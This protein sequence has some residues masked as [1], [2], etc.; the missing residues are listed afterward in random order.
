MCLF[1]CTLAEA[2]LLAPSSLVYAVVVF[3]AHEDEPNWRQSTDRDSV[4]HL[5]CDLPSFLL[6]VQDNVSPE[7][8]SVGEGRTHVNQLLVLSGFTTHCGPLCSEVITAYTWFPFPIFP[9][10][11]HLPQ[12]PVQS[13]NLV[14]PS[15]VLQTGEHLGIVMHRPVKELH[16]GRTYRQTDR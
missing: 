6:P 8:S 14:F 5:L 16:R 7:T 3:V 13:H 10:S 12:N 11:F 15:P 4:V 2:S 1:V 9:T